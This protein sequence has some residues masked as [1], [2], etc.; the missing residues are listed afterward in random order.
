MSF[1]DDATKAVLRLSQKKNAYIT[2]LN[3]SQ[4]GK[5]IDP[6][7]RHHRQAVTARAQAVWK[8]YPE[9]DTLQA[10]LDGA[11]Q[12]LGNLKRPWACT[13]DAAATFVLTF[14]RVGAPGRRGTWSSTT[15]LLGPSSATLGAKKKH[16]SGRLWD[17]SWEQGGILLFF[18]P[19]F[20]IHS[21]EGIFNA[22]T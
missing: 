15:T 17:I 22:L 7:F 10:A 2:M 1:R 4:T 14:V 9:M 5:T 6:A 21:S 20:G 12:R 16:C 19:S 11:A 13:P 8:G 18:L 3:H